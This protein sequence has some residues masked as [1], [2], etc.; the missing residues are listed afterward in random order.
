MIGVLILAVLFI[1]LKRKFSSITVETVDSS[2]CEV[3]EARKLARL[4]VEDV[5][6]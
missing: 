4:D 2:I 6:T 5:C 3:K 1:A